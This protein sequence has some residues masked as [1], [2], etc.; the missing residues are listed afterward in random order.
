MVNNIAGMRRVTPSNIDIWDGTK[1]E[2][3]RWTREQLAEMARRYMDPAKV[4]AHTV[5][6]KVFVAFNEPEA[7]RVFICPIIQRA[8][9]K[10]RVMVITPAG[11]GQWVDA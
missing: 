6:F 10:P 4:E 7:K 1:I 5:T 3:E 8:R 9:R 11:F 2:G